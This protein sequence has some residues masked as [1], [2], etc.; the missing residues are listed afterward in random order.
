MGDARG[1]L[2]LMCRWIKMDAYRKST[3]DRGAKEVGGGGI[4]LSERLSPE[5]GDACFLACPRSGLYMV[6]GIP[7]WNALKQHLRSNMGRFV[8][9]CGLSMASAV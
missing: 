7:C 6:L 1:E 2:W 4:H 9:V 5:D 3:R 8:E